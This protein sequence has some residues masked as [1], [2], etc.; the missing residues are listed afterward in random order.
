MLDLGPVEPAHDLRVGVHGEAVQR[1][2]GEDDQVHGRQVA[3]RLGDQRADA[4][5]LPR[6]VV[7]GDDDRILDLHQPDDHAIGRRFEDVAKFLVG[8]LA[9]R[10]ILHLAHVQPGSSVLAADQ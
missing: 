8:P 2:F 10:D 7:P 1:V 6:Q 5:G 4:L 3:P 9:K